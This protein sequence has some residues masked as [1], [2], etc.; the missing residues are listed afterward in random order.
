MEA[1]CLLLLSCS[2]IRLGS[3]TSPPL[4]SL[5]PPR[6][7]AQPPPSLP[8]FIAGA[9][10]QA[11]LLL[12]LSPV[13]IHPAGRT[14]SLPPANLIPPLTQVKPKLPLAAALRPATHSPSPHC[15]PALSPPSLPGQSHCPQRLGQ[16]KQEGLPMGSTEADPLTLLA[17]LP[18]GTAQPW[19][20]LRGLCLPRV[21]GVALSAP[22]EAWMPCPFASSTSG[23]TCLNNT[24]L[25]CP[26]SGLHAQLASVSCC[27]DPCE[28][29]AK[30]PPITGT[31]RLTGRGVHAQRFLVSQ[32]KQEETGSGLA[33]LSC[34]C[35]PVPTS[36]FPADSSPTTPLGPSS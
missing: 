3:K 30:S 16:S 35:C 27:V 19:H 18:P 21:S 15:T 31:G 34:S 32:D 28:P 25:N 6:P 5:Q 12:P 1:S 8:W 17:P 2:L 14:C 9:S 11:S 20:F 4:I 22:L 29:Q 33:C 23:H 7:D 13:I 36:L 24:S 10:S 26:S